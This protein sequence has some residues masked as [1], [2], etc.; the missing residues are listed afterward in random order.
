MLV[1]G[2]TRCGKT[3]AIRRF[4]Q[5]S[6]TEQYKST[7]GADFTE[8]NIVVDSNLTVNLQIW[9]MAGQDGFAKLTRAY[10]R[11]AKGAVI[12]CDITRESTIDAIVN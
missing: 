12:V 10:F 9:D 6:F 5:R 7:I 4:V 8:K 11:E 3:S 2:N 1:V